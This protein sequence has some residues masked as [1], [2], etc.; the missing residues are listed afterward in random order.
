[1]VAAG[2]LVESDQFALFDAGK[3]LAADGVARPFSRDRQGLLLGD[4]VAA[5]VLESGRSSAGRGRQPIAQLAGWG[6]AGDAHHPCQPAPDGRGLARAI[7]AALARAGVSAEQLGYIN[8]N[9]TG[10]QLS[11]AAEAAALATALG[12]LAGQVPISS[13]KSMHGHA[14]EASAL[15]ELVITVL[16][17]A[18]GKLGV[19]AGY[20]GPDPDCPLDLIVDGPR[21]L[22]A[23]YAL[24]LNSAFGGANTALLVGRRHDQPLMS[25]SAQSTEGPQPVVRH[26]AWW[27]VA[28][29]GE[30]PVVPGFVLS[31]FNPLV[32]AVADRCLTEHYA[33]PPEPPGDRQR[34]GLVLVSRGGD[35]VSAEHVRQTVADGNR[36]GP[37]FF[38]QSVPN[39]IAGHVTA[40]WGLGGP[41]VCISPVGPPVAEGIAE[42]D[43]A[44]VRR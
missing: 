10:T 29:D 3:A 36:L 2:Y 38:F 26:E 23:P 30:P 44:D 16:S 22:A 12:P 33:K 4:A 37:L 42:A 7:E 32:A 34:T 39:S 21:Q 5:V 27:W 40:R 25:A 28:E 35:R 20:L 41:V 19:N 13:T 15:L 17:L 31:A 24:S 14:L 11:D 8:A 18:E 9:A 1:M 6:R 43:A